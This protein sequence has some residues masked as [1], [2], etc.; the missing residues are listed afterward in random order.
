MKPS[1]DTGV[2]D[3]QQRCETLIIIMVF[4]DLWGLK[5]HKLLTRAEGG[6]T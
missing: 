6:G 3:T 2:N 4:T 5:E 1:H